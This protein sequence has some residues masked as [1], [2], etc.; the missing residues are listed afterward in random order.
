MANLRIRVS[1]AGSAIRRPPGAM[2][3]N[4]RPRRTRRMPGLQSLVNSRLIED[5]PQ[6]PLLPPGRQ[7]PL[8]RGTGQAHCISQRCVLVGECSHRLR[9]L[10]AKYVP[11]RIVNCANT[12][13]R[14]HFRAHFGLFH[15][16]PSCVATNAWPS[17]GP[18]K[19]RSQ[20]VCRTVLTA[21]RGSSGPLPALLPTLARRRR[22]YLAY[23]QWL[24]CRTAG[25]KR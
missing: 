2:Y 23:H 5:T 7:V 11:P 25:S 16:S 13:H 9:R 6:E 18:S 4:W 24:S 19:E 8:G 12:V 1:R 3:E 17:P 21:P 10:T 14:S 15:P 20:T 22:K